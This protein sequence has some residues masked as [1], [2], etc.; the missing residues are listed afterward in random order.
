M[1]RST[2]LLKHQ[3]VGSTLRH[4][5][6]RDRDS[7]HLRDARIVK[8][9]I[10][11]AD[12]PDHAMLA[13]ARM[14]GGLKGCLIRAQARF[15]VYLGARIPE[16]NLGGD[17]SGTEGADR[18]VGGAH[19][20]DARLALQRFRQRAR[21]SILRQGLESLAAIRLAG[22][23]QWRAVRVD[24]VEDRRH[25]HQFRL[26]VGKLQGVLRGYVLNPHGKSLI[27]LGRYAAHEKQQHR[28]HGYPQSSLRHGRPPPFAPPAEQGY[29]T[30]ELKVTYHRAL[31]DARGPVRAKGRVIAFGRHT[32]L[33]KAD[34]ST[35]P[36][37]SAQ[38][39]RP[40]VY[41]LISRQRHR[42]KPVGVVVRHSNRGRATSDMGHSRRWAN[43]GASANHR[44]C[45]KTPAFNLRVKSPSRFRQ[46]KEEFALWPRSEKGQ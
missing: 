10:H 27:R 46:S 3:V 17:I 34:S 41:C 14:R 4:R 7:E 19:V 26:A 45:V 44:G 18:G 35:T 39:L 23:E 21:R 40:R 25:C 28:E 16:H 31:T 33:P 13:G 11:F 30:L 29:A 8:A 2:V 1:A 6:G 12:G 5:A 36:V 42:G 32:V 15:L 43:P 9:V 37:S 22:R 24:D 20:D 38:R